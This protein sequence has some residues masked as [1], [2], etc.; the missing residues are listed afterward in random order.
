MTVVHFH[1]LVFGKPACFADAADHLEA[2]LVPDAVT[3]PACASYL[4]HNLNSSSSL[5][6]AAREHKARATRN[7]E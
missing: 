6:R 2:T 4:G 5:E 3:C 7:G 1:H